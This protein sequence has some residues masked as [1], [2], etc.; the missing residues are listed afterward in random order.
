MHPT[1]YATKKAV[2]TILFFV[3]PFTLLPIMLAALLINEELHPPSQVATTIPQSAPPE[4]GSVMSNID[5]RRGTMERPMAVYTRVPGRMRGMMAPI[6]TVMKLNA[7]A[8]V[9]TS[10][11]LYVE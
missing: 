9:P 11:V 2:D 8:G 1:Q 7:P 3:L 10:I 4:Y 5:P 6:Q